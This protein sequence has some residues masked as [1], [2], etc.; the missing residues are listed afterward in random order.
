MAPKIRKAKVLFICANCPDTVG[1]T[2]RFTRLTLRLVHDSLHLKDSE[3]SQ[4]INSAGTA[5]IR[6]FHVSSPHTT[7]HEPKGRASSPLR[8]DGCNHAFRQRKERRAPVLRSTNA[9]RG[10]QPSATAEGGPARISDFGLLSDFGF[11]P[12]DF[13][14]APCH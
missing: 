7:S 6:R 12:S 8:A 3:L 2:N 14:H 13:P 10:H 5:L 9:K 1:V 11:R 4:P